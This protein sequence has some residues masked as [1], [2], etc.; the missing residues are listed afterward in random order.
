M[1][2][3]ATANHVSRINVWP[4]RSLIYVVAPGLFISLSYFIGQNLVWVWLA[5]LAVYVVF[6]S[7]LGIT[8]Q[9]SKEE[10][11]RKLRPV[12]RTIGII[13]WSGFLAMIY[14]FLYVILFD[15]ENF[16]PQ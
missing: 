13:V 11:R 16:F 4:Y 15:R 14:L 8:D 7:A 2:S 10:Y 6:L 9:P 5:V 3:E 1:H 12:V